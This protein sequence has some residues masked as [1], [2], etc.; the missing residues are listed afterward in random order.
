VASNR[1]SG[2]QIAWKTITYRSVMLLILLGIAIVAVGAR[3]AF[4]SF[5]ENTV[6]AAGNVFTNLLERVASPENSGKHG[7]ESQQ[8]HITALDGTVRI[9]KASGESWVK[10][11]YNVP[12]DKGDVIQT[13]PEGMAKIAFNDGT[14]Y[15]V[16]QD[17]L[18]VIA[19]NSS[20]ERQQTNV[21]VNVTTGTVD[22]AT[23]TYVQG[24][25]SQVIVDGATAS[26]AP[27]SAA[28]VRK[29]SKSQQDEL[30]VTK[31]QGTVQRGQETIQLTD[32]EKATFKANE[33]PLEK[34]KEIGPPTPISPANM[35]PIFAPSPE[36]AIEFSWTPMTNAKA[37]RLQISRNPYFSSLIVDRNVESSAVMVSGLPE[38]PYYWMVRSEDLS[39]K[40]SVESEKN[41]FTI[42][43]KEAVSGQIRLELDPLIQHGRVIELTGKTEIGARVMVNGHEVP[44]IGGDGG[45]HY[46]MPPLANGESVITITAQNARGGVNTQQQ[47]VVIQ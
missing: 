24:S 12:L 16:K 1:K 17:S 5:T 46:F 19:E 8:A 27:E 9:K 30:L 31:G 29:D 10:A 33:G 6:K 20:N 39:G 3:L 40:E 13:G 38:G 15:T 22:L 42:I 43:A 28:R 11:D 26:L 25:S 4:P 18:I 41:R 14:N 45:F 44:V 35:M 21:A 47:K 2:I 36:K 7:N 23:G 32:W 34:I 37:Y